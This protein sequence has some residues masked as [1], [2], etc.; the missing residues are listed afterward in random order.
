MSPPVEIRYLPTR[1]THLVWAAG[2]A[3]DGSLY[4]FSTLC[5]RRIVAMN[6]W[7]EDPRRHERNGLP[8][9]R[10]CKPCQRKAA[11]Q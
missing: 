3:E 1:V 5:G 7:A 10:P 9:G 6:R 11:N 2:G 4:G 8:V